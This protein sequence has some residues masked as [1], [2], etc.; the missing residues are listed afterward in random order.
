MIDPINIMLILSAYLLGSIPS[1]VW[2]GKVFFKTD[3]RDHGSGNAGATNTFRV[4]GKKAGIVV[5][6]LDVSKGFFA[7]SIPHLLYPQLNGAMLI[8]LQIALGLSA[9]VGH[10]YPVFA[11]FR[12]GKGVATML[13]VV[14]ALNLYP[15]LAAMAIF[16]LIFILFK[17]VSLASIVSAL[18]YP[19]FVIFVFTT[20]QSVMVLF[21]LFVSIVI[22]LTHQKNIE[23]LLNKSENK[24]ALKGKSQV[25]LNK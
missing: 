5:L 14:L 20:E 23:R 22:V 9:V 2:I 17:Y 13:G 15:A 8:H 24:M 6:L 1:A 7:V 4:L 16:I 21:S 11:G 3:V 18:S 19:F 25:V 12:G 10:L